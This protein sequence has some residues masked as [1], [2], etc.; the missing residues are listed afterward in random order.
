MNSKEEAIKKAYGRIIPE[1]DEN[2]WIRYGVH[3]PK[4]LPY[5]EETEDGM[6]NMCWRPKSLKGIENNNGWIKI[7]SE[8]DLPKEKGNYWVVDKF[9]ES[10]PVQEYFNPSALKSLNNRWMHRF[11]HYQTIIKPEKPLF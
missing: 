4:T 8:S 1:L 9:M 3:S 7:E 6:N 11:T 10:N 2:G 5:F